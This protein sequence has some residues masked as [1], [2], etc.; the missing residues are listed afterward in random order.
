VRESEC[1]RE[2]RGSE[3]DSRQ[4]GSG[5]AKG[6]NCRPL[7]ARRTGAQGGSFTP[8]CQRREQDGPNGQDAR[9][10][11]LLPATYQGLTT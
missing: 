3:F 7:L 2:R 1:V 5:V 10:Y 6:P 11:S 9:S 4:A 8:V